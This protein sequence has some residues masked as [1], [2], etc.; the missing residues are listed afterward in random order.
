MLMNYFSCG[1]RLCLSKILD[2]S[3]TVESS[4]HL[5][6]IARARSRILKKRK[7]IIIM[8]MLIV[9]DEY[10]IFFIEGVMSVFVFPLHIEILI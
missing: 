7:P 4:V 3:L 6:S 1:E 5:V 8:C 10:R 9:R 2:I